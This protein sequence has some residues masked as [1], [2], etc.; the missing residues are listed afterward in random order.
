MSRIPP[1]HPRDHLGLAR[2][3]PGV[4]AEPG[5]DQRS[6]ELGRRVGRDRPPL[7]RAPPP[8]VASNTSPCS[9]SETTPAIASPSRSHRDRDGEARVAVEVVGGPVDRV[10]HPAQAARALDV[11]ALLAE[12]RVVG[13]GREDPVD[14]Q[15]LAGAVD[16]GDACRSPTTSSARRRAAAAGPRAAGASASA[17]SSPGEREELARDR[18]R[19]RTVVGLSVAMVDADGRRRDQLRPRRAERRHPARRGGARGGGARRSTDDWE[20]ALSYGTG[21]GHPGALRVDRHR[22]PR[23]RRRAGDG[24]Q[25]LDGGRRRC[26]SAT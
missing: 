13:A 26:C 11:G 3:L 9:G 2:A 22:A 15:P 5:R 21:I 17:A 19:P 14:D 16:L 12:D 10:D 1:D 20:R 4:V 18:P 8:R 23:D 25:R 24:H 7:R 6:A